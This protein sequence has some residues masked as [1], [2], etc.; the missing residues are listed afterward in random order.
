MN[1]KMNKCEY[2]RIKVKQNQKAKHKEFK[3]NDEFEM[4]SQAEVSQFSLCEEFEMKN[5]HKKECNEKEFALNMLL[6][7]I[8]LGEVI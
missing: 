4:E 2:S 8:N 7:N 1:F 6:A 5:N 3:Y